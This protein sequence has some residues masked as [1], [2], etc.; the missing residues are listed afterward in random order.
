MANKAW[1]LTAPARPIPGRPATK[2][3]MR[4]ALAPAT[5]S[6]APTAHP[7]P[8]KATRPWASTLATTRIVASWWSANRGIVPYMWISANLIP[9]PRTVSTSSSR[10]LKDST[11]SLSS[12]RKKTAPGAFLEKNDPLSRIRRVLNHMGGADLALCMP[13]PYPLSL[14][15]RLRNDNAGKARALTALVLTVDSLSAGNARRGGIAYIRWDVSA[16]WRCARAA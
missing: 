4:L 14:H 8:R 16:H 3:P 2:R 11:S 9:R 7:P 6:L 10:L 15:I 13:L 1:P 12:T 5:G